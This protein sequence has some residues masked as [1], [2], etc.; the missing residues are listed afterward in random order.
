MVVRDGALFAS[1]NVVSGSPVVDDVVCNG[2]ED[3]ILQCS[4][5]VVSRDCAT[6]GVICAGKLSSELLAVYVSVLDHPS[7]PGSHG[8]VCPRSSHN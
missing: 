7:R 3:S 6:A 8:R 2:D 1:A 5:S 4:H